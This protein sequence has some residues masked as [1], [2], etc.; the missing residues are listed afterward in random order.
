MRKSG[1]YIICFVLAFSFLKAQ[2]V[3]S[4][5]YFCVVNEQDTLIG[6]HEELQVPNGKFIM[7]KVLYFKDVPHMYVVHVDVKVA[8]DEMKVRTEFDDVKTFRMV[9]GE[10]QSGKRVGKW[11][12]LNGVN[13]WSSC[14]QRWTE[15]EE[16]YAK[17]KDSV[18]ATLHLDY[19]TKMY[20][21]STQDFK[22]GEVY[23]RNMKSTILFE[24][25]DDLCRYWHET[26]SVLLFEG[27]ESDIDWHL[28]MIQSNDLEERIKFYSNAK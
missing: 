13:S 18:F 12:Y 28:M 7:Y 1:V 24:C 9:Y 22:K 11:R 21:S 20:F 23:S 15:K 27:P 10:Y 19:L 25:K 5:S 6:H 26:D 16:F 17:D 2:R 8:F 4:V 3:D 14:Y